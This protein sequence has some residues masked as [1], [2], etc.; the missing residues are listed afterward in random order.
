MLLIK[1]GELKWLKL[2][3][4]FSIGLSFLFTSLGAETFK[5]FKSIAV[6]P[7]GGSSFFLN[8]Q[9]NTYEPMSD[10]VIYEVKKPKII[11]S[12]RQKKIKAVGPKVRIVISKEKIYEQSIRKLVEK[13]IV[14]DFFSTPLSFNIPDRLQNAKFYPQSQKGIGNF[15]STA[16]STEYAYL[17]SEI[18]QLKDEMNLND[19]GLYLLISKIS[20]EI[21]LERDNSKLFTWFM[22]NKLGYKVR[23][24]ILKKHI[25]L[26]FQT[27]QSLNYTPRYNIDDKDFYILDSSTE[28]GVIYTYDQDYPDANN[29]FDLSLEKLPKLSLDIQEK[30]IKFKEYSNEYIIKYKYNQNLID[31]MATYP[32]AQSDVFF[33]APL[34][35]I[36]Y[37]S[38]AKS[39][40][41]YLDRKKASTALNFVLHFVQNAFVYQSDEE[42]FKKEKFMFAQ[43]TLY[44]DKSDSE[45]R[46]V[47]FSYIIKKFF[48]F[49][50][51]GVVYKDHM[52]IA[53]YIPIKGDSVQF[54]SRK[55]IVADPTYK[56][57]N[58]G[59]G[60]SKYKF[61]KPKI[62]SLKEFT[63]QSGRHL[64]SKDLSVEAVNTMESCYTDG[65]KITIS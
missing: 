21:F 5:D 13:D 64:Y 54:G 32:Q 61:K 52:S 29:S 26:I 62:K 8:Q 33:K 19:W 7:T 11:S 18:E 65:G 15:F 4:H 45:D 34:D 6:K 49:N 48:S 39:L 40:K 53:L 2:F 35:D 30:D 63:L 55:Y 10:N 43:E 14:I 44:Y 20:D 25:A 16:S 42:Q 28:R 24:G 47:L 50:L 56:N 37:Q 36:S 17:L 22:L 57:A 41:E 27:K 12:L 46:A 3:G 59:Q 51:V 1:V 9:W 38:I 60:I 23:A 31:F 58:V